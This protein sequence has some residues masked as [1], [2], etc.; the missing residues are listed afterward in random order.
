MYKTYVYHCPPQSE[1][2][3]NT[4]YLT[5]LKKPKGEIWFST[6]P[7]GH[8]RYSPIQCNVFAELLVL[9]VLKQIIL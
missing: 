2:K 5:P 7:V 6:V 8:N 9:M 1:R 3:A 4:F